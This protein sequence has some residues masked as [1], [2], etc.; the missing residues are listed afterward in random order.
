MG[1]GCCEGIENASSTMEVS[2]RG[3]TRPSRGTRWPHCEMI[4][5]TIREGG[6]G[7]NGWREQVG[8]VQEQGLFGSRESD[9]GK[10]VLLRIEIV[11]TDVCW[12]WVG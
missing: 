11:S 12:M 1:K 6:G 2:A 5:D 4:V 8:P 9:F 10:A 7:A 3:G